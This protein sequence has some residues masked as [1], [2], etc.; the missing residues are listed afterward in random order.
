MAMHPAI[1]EFK[2]PSKPGFEG[3]SRS[4]FSDQLLRSVLERQVR[5]ITQASSPERLPPMHLIKGWPA[6]ELSH[7]QKFAEIYRID[8]H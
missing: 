3:F 7:C 1:T 6:G 5:R 8:G 4:E 2:H